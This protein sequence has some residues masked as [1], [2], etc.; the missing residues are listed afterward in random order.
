MVDCGFST[1]E[2]LKR[3]ETKTSSPEKITAILVTHEHADHIGGVVGFANRFDIPVYLSHGTSLHKKC[4]KLKPE[5]KRIINSHNSFSIGQLTVTPVT[6]PHDAREATQ[7][8]FE[9]NGQ[10]LGLL[11]DVGHITSHIIDSFECC[12][13]LLLEFNYDENMLWEGRYPVSLKRRVAGNL[14]HLS[15]DQAIGFL[16]SCRLEK[17]VSLVIMHK[18]EENNCEKIINKALSDLESISHVSYFIACQKKG[19][20]WQKVKP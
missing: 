11:T 9:S 16:Q 18:S 13:S 2:V 17:L 19:F 6:V 20:D 5:L 3:L 1:K 14:G 7:F 10:K 8:V 12:D 4:E 15:N